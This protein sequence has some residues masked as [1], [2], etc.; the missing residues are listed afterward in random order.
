M[1]CFCRA[2]TAYVNQ[3]VVAER[4]DVGSVFCVYVYTYAHVKAKHK[5]ERF[6][7]VH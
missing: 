7:L 4:K 1:E 5:V 6:L 2:V 3:L